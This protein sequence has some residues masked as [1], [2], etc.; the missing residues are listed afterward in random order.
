MTTELIYWM[1]LPELENSKFLR[2]IKTKQTKKPNGT[3][4]R[5]IVNILNSSLKKNQYRKLTIP[6]TQ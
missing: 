1:I 5:L 6:S 2:Q 4:C 3:I